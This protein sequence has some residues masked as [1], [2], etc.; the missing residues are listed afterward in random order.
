MLGTPP[1]KIDQ[2]R[3][4]VVTP[5]MALNP[6][7]VPLQSLPGGLT[8]TTTCVHYIMTIGH[9]ILGFLCAQ[10]PLNSLTVSQVFI[11]SYKYIAFNLYQIF[12]TTWIQNSLFRVKVSSQLQ[13]YMYACISGQI[14]GS[15]LIVINCSLTFQL[16][17]LTNINPCLYSP[18]P[19][20]TNL[21]SC[22]DLAILI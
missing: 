12:K 1:K 19:D 11:C 17:Q 4:P 10:L 5:F 20:K 2:F 15:G 9:Y 16:K 18:L 3:V 7:G 14:T 8:K 21:L 22:L 13:K 6:T